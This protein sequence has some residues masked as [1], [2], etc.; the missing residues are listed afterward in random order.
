MPEL[1]ERPPYQKP[2]RR[3]IISKK[4]LDSRYYS[5]RVIAPLA[6][7]VHGHRGA[8]AE[9]VRRVSAFMGKSVHPYIVTR[10]LSLDPEKRTEPSFGNGLVLS[11]I[12]K[13]MRT[14]YRTGISPQYTTGPIQADPTTVKPDDEDLPPVEEGTEESPPPEPERTKKA[15]QFR[16]RS[17][18]S[19]SGNHRKQS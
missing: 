5:D 11:R 10:W 15:L 18:R 8:M 17:G 12:I 9:V 6:A 3:H 7:W 14:E 13:T 1:P 4:E 19:R 2:A 16:V